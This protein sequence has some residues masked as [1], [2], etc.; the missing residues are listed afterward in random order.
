MDRTNW[1]FGQ[2]NINILTITIVYRGI[3]IPL[4][5]T[6][7]P[8]RGNSNNQER[9]ALYERVALVLSKTVMKGLLADREF[10][11]KDWLV[12]LLKKE[13]PFVIRCKENIKA[14]NAK[15]KLLPLNLML[16]NLKPAKAVIFTKRRGIM[17]YWFILLRHGWWM[18]SC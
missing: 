11:G 6:L 13:I 12:W 9:I 16:R 2:F 4:I 17:G 18:E 15:G 5:W 10:V 14:S 3:A 7:L 1:K 8:K